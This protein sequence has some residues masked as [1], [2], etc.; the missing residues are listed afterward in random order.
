M[1]DPVMNAQRMRGQGYRGRALAMALFA[2]LFCAVSLSEANGGDEKRSK[3]RVVVS[4]FEPRDL[5]LQS[6]LDVGIS[7]ESFDSKVIPCSDVERKVSSV[8]Q[9]ASN[10]GGY[11]L[12][13]R[14]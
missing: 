3:P 8:R 1:H 13:L 10:W 14:V 12:Q 7:I 2:C 4:S 6:N 11:S 5:A 9:L